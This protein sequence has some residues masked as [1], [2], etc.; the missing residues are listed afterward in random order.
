MM[1][2]GMFTSETR[3]LCE[4]VWSVR[5]ISAVQ[6]LR[7]EINLT[8]KCFPL[9]PMMESCDLFWCKGIYN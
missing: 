1:R 3:G 8:E 6:N 5:K 2:R 7:G 9:I 4:G